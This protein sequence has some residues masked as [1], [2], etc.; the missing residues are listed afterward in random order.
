MNF[1]VKGSRSV[2]LQINLRSTLAKLFLLT[3]AISRIIFFFNGTWSGYYGFYSMSPEV[4]PLDRYILACSSVLGVWFSIL[5][6]TDSLKHKKNRV[7][8][9]LFAFMLTFLFV[10]WT[11]DFLGKNSSTLLFVGNF[12]PLTLLFFGSFYAGSNTKLM[13]SISY[14]AKYIAMIFLLLSLVYSVQFYV[15]Y[16]S[17]GVRYGY[18]HALIYFEYGFYALMLYVCGYKEFKFS[19]NRKMLFMLVILSVIL[20]VM[21]VSRGWIIQSIALLIYAYLGKEAGEKSYKSKNATKA[22]TVIAVIGLIVV[23]IIQFAPELVETLGGR[24]NQDTRSLQLIEFMT[25]MDIKKFV[26]GQGYNATYIES[27]H[28][29]YAYIDNQMLMMIFR[30]GLIPTVIYLRFVISSALC[31]FKYRDGYGFAGVMWLLALN[32]LA[33]YLGFGIDIPNFCMMLIIGRGVAHYQMKG[34]N[35]G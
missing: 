16:G 17:V 18:S 4:G 12:T 33:I 15:E 35:E 25:Q 19:K 5:C 22:V 30:Y 3:F 8:T 10:L 9:I 27:A 34:R 1:N 32:G 11:M 21:S 14:F 28:G 2:K 23:A 29:T 6:F 24:L 26:L 13:A 20:A 7:S 31:F